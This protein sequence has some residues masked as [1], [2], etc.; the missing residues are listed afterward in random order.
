MILSYSNN[1]DRELIKSVELKKDKWGNV[2]LQPLVER[3]TQLGFPLKDTIISYYNSFENAWVFAGKDPISAGA[4]IP[5][6][7]IDLRQRLQL[8]CRP[9]VSESNTKAEQPE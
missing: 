8:R 2:L 1:D 5:T 3:I 4:S 9:Q 6:E 7:D